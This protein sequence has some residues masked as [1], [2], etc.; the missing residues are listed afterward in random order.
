MQVLFERLKGE[1]HAKEDALAALGR[2]LADSTAQL[3]RELEVARQ[4]QSDM[5]GSCWR[6]RRTGPRCSRTY[7]RRS[8]M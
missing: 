8:R 1:L 2:R 3:Q 4:A 7:W 5:A 6:R